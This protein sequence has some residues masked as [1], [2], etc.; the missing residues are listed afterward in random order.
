MSDPIRL[1]TRGLATLDRMVR[2]RLVSEIIDAYE[3]WGQRDEHDADGH[4]GQD[5]RGQGYDRGQ[6]RGHGRRNTR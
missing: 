1:G 2:H 3:R 5:G 4:R 6:R